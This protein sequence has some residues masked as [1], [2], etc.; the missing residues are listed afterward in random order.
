MAENYIDYLCPV[1]HKETYLCF[2]YYSHDE[3]ALDENC[4][5]CGAA[6]P[7]D[8]WNKIIEDEVTDSISSRTDR[9]MDYGQD[10]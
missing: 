7:S 10:R 4:D 9:A 6:V 3:Y 2:T 5:E 1:C 8:I